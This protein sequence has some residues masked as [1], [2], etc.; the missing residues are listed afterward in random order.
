MSPGPPDIDLNGIDHQVAQAISLAREAVR[1]DPRSAEAWGMLG[2]VLRAHDYHHEADTCFDRAEALNPRDPRWPYLISR[3]PR[4]TDPD[5]ALP[6]LRRAADHCGDVAAP[7]LTL[8]ELLLDKGSLE[9]AEEQFRRVLQNEPANPRAN[10]G[11]GQIALARGDLTEAE[12]HLERSVKEAPKVRASHAALAD[13][14]RR[15]GKEKEAARESKKVARLPED[16]VWPDPYLSEVT[17]VW[18]GLKARLRL[19]E[20]LTKRGRE[21]E[22]LKHLGALVADYPEEYKTHLSL[23]QCLNRMGRTV[24]AEPALRTA[25]RLAPTKGQPQFELGFALQHQRKVREAADRYRTAIRLEPNLHLPHFNLSF[26]LTSAGDRAEAIR[27]LRETV[28]LRPDYAPAF[29]HLGTL[30]IQERK[31]AEAIKE[32]E[33][34]AKQAPNDESMQKLLSEARADLLRSQKK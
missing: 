1:R 11:L 14:Y 20:E 8:G 33:L 2:K 5:G 24:D 29:K 25:I 28:R 9:E 15:Q 6:Y 4:G 34:G 22:A 30:L 16:W 21:E 7:R 23:G 10:L 3:G 19:A 18:V 17:A 27:E 13:I 12:K 31:Y 32:L 26:L